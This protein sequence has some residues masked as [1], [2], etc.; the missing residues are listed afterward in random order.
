MFVEFLI[1]AAGAL[2]ALY[3]WD[4]LVSLAGFLPQPAPPTPD[5]SRRRFACIVCAH[6]E[7]EVVGGVVRALRE[8]EYP[9][10]RVRV[11]VVADN[12][13]DDT[14][15]IAAEEGAE[16]LVRHDPTRK[17]KG[18]ALQWGI[19]HLLGNVEFDALCVFD[20]DNDVERNFLSVMDAYL[21]DGHVAIQCYLDTLNPRESWVTR[22]IALAYYVTNRFWMRARGRAG[23]RSR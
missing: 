7:A 16:V 13:T 4:L 3:G 10:D 11:F 8:Q 6:N 23:I 21:A 5:G 20:A 2:F 9:A 1:V 18:Y 17:T 12:C 15:R 19:E 22:S 14:A